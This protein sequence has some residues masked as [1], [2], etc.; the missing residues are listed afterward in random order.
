MNLPVSR[1]HGVLP[2]E[3][4]RDQIAL[5][6]RT[7]CAGATDDEL[8]LYLHQCKARG[9]DPM[10]G[11]MYA[12]KRWDSAAKRDVMTY[13]MGY[14]GL[15]S[16]AH[17][18]NEM[19]GFSDTQWCD[20]EGTW[21]D[22]WTSSDPPVAARAT[23]HRKGHDHGYKGVARFEAFVARK[24]DG[25]PNTFW[26]DK[27]DI[28]LMK[29]AKSL[30]LREAF[31]LELQ[32]IYSDEEMQHARRERPDGVEVEQKWDVRPERQ[33]PV[34]ARDE[35]GVL[36]MQA[37]VANHCALCDEAIAV[38]EDIGFREESPQGRQAVHWTCYQARLE[39]LGRATDGDNEPEDA[40][41]E[42]PETEV[43]G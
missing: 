3:L 27:A 29:C 33:R 7:F 28:M 32:G 21:H 4:N 5:V 12:I 2:A 43:Q 1:T 8:A 35:N 18:T 26:R 13:Q 14:A 30:A 24:K 15:L 16:I 9:F 38:G 41:I 17:S 31:P 34:Q 23:V 11:Q 42:E 10:G 25:D 39:E 37:G 22:E 36:R 40:A 19:N 6:K 20:G